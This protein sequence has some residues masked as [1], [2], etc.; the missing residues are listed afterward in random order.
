[1]CGASSGS[2]GGACG[3]TT[4]DSGVDDS[5]SSGSNSLRRWEM[6]LNT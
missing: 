1:M 2:R 4:G 6:I 3:G 5:G